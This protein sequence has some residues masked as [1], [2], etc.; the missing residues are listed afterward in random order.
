MLLFESERT[1]S[2]IQVQVQSAQFKLLPRLSG[3][4]VLHTV[5]RSARFRRSSRSQVL[6]KSELLPTFENYPTLDPRK[7]CQPIEPQNREKF[8]SKQNCFK[9]QNALFAP[10]A[11][12]FVMKATFPNQQVITSR[13]YD[14]NKVFVKGHLLIKL[15]LD[16]VRFELIQPINLVQLDSRPKD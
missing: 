7:M 1:K 13:C 15:V 2:R 4:L 3:L 16:K 11:K 12:Q 14:H 8:F 10:Q 6:Q 5:R 9:I